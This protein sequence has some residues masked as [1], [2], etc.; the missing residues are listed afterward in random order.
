M[1]MGS[2]L[3]ACR[4]F[5]A[6]QSMNG[7]KHRARR[8]QSQVSTKNGHCRVVQYHRP[9]GTA[10]TVWLH[11]SS[12]GSKESKM[13]ANK[14]AKSPIHQSFG[15]LHAVRLGLSAE[16]RSRSVRALNRLF[17]HA[18]ALRDLYKKA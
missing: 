2:G 10:A 17:A 11:E 5:G 12:H 7:R 8:G 14:E 4:R 3:D 6:T 9:L 15:S 13:S 18:M 16:T 1:A